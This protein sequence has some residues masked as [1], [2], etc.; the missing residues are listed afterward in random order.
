MTSND[1][2]PSRWYKAPERSGLVHGGS[3]RGEADIL[4]Y[5][6][7][8]YCAAGCRCVS[9][10]PFL[11][12]KSSCPSSETKQTS[13]DPLECKYFSGPGDEEIC[14]R[15]LKEGLGSKTKAV[16]LFPREAVVCSTVRFHVKCCKQQL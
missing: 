2:P 1:S 11:P 3:L 15:E 7:N 4:L 6:R 12:M 16:S 8:A 14:F 9:L 5:W 13:T 10:K